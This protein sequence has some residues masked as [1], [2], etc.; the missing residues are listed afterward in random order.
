VNEPVLI[1]SPDD[2]L[3]GPKH[4]TVYVLSMVVIYVLDGNINTSFKHKSFYR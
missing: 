2:G 1:V 3:I 4:V